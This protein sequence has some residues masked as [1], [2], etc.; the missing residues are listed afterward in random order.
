M[1]YLVK[2]KSKKEEYEQLIKEVF[3]HIQYA[4]FETFIRKNK[5][6]IIVFDQEEFL[7][8]IETIKKLSR[9]EEL[10]FVVV[11]ISKD[12]STYDLP[13]V[14]VVPDFNRDVMEKIKSRILKKMEKLTREKIKNIQR[15]ELKEYESVG[16]GILIIDDEE[17]IVYA[18]DLLLRFLK[19]KYPLEKILNLKVQVLMR[20]IA[21]EFDIEKL[22]NQTSNQRIKIRLPDGTVEER[23]ISVT[24]RL[25]AD[26]KIDGYILRIYE[27]LA[28]EGERLLKDIQSL[29]EELENI[30]QEVEYRF[31]SVVPG[32][33]KKFA[34]VLNLRGLIFI[35]FYVAKLWEF[36]E[37]TP[38]IL[39]YKNVNGEYISRFVYGFNMS[40]EDKE[41]CIGSFSFE[42]FMG[43]YRPF[44]DIMEVENT[45][46]LKE[47]IK[48]RGK[49]I[50][51]ILCLER[52]ELFDNRERHLVKLFVQSL[53]E[54]IDYSIYL[55][56]RHLVNL[57]E[58]LAQSHGNS[59]VVVV[60]KDG[61]VIYV[62]EKF[63][64]IFNLKISNIYDTSIE[65]IP[66]L[67][68]NIKVLNRVLHVIKNSIPMRIERWIKFPGGEEKYLIISGIPASEI[69]IPGYIWIFE[70]R[71]REKLRELREYYF[72]RILESNTNITKT[73]RL[74]WLDISKD[75]PSEFYESILKIFVHHLAEISDG[76][77]TTLIDPDSENV[78]CQVSKNLPPKLTG[79]ELCRFINSLDDLSSQFGELN[80]TIFNLNKI[81]HAGALLKAGFEWAIRI[82]ISSE[83]ENERQIGTIVMLS[84]A[85]G[86]FYRFIQAIYNPGIYTLNEND[87]NIFAQVAQTMSYHVGAFR[88][89]VLLAETKK[90]HE[91]FYK[92]S[93]DLFILADENRKITLAN[94]TA[95]YLLCRE[96]LEGKDLVNVLRDIVR[97][98]VEKLFDLQEE[99]EESMV[100]T[101]PR[102]DEEKWL[103]LIIKKIKVG[104]INEFIVIGHDVSE[105]YRRRLSRNRAIIGLIAMLLNILAEK[106]AI[107][108][109]HSIN[110]A[111]IVK[112]I[113]EV[114]TKENPFGGRF[115]NEA[116][117]FCL[118]TGALL[119]DI[120]KINM[121]SSY[122]IKPPEQLNENSLV[123][124]YYEEHPLFGAELLS[125]L[126]LPCDNKIPKWVMEHHECLDGSGFPKG[127]VGD[128]ISLGGRIIGVADRI[129]NEIIR[130]P[131][132]KGVEDLRILLR[133]MK[134]SGKYDMKVLNI[135]E[136]IYE[137]KGGRFLLSLNSTEKYEKREADMREAVDELL[138][139]LLG[140]E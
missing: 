48:G 86:E 28:F 61:S 39:V 41:K 104:D 2:T 89:N 94:D 105:F 53:R 59:G 60:E 71:T 134:D 128:K 138:G 121:A 91:E 8:K 108:A 136:K 97:E 24:P 50:Y 6:G 113:L 18:N 125:N 102:C 7:K 57:V 84:R 137:K 25:R 101:L 119:H 96:D 118:V 64:E 75:S 49:E 80:V 110:V 100:V 112:E 65:T 140:E 127:L 13:D 131:Q 73:L 12:L 42:K 87:Q 67:R 62:N 51:G 11:V 78:F 92:H 93:N 32:I 19:N 1:R 23:S 68:D 132:R 139:P 9:E 120:G 115:V 111:I 123:R 70:D 103:K 40:N 52:P 74:K 133:K 56:E 33:L 106:S 135:V 43:L 5:V 15:D 99:E 85:E 54:L 27:P 122:L 66:G 30:G 14:Y 76:L 17:K 77:I 88:R 82:P 38:F 35:P 69:N 107:I 3:P 37:G 36:D 114:I 26:N 126:G 21:P 29:I 109:R 81:P 58:K 16:V 44:D 47:F 130:K 45:V 31:F 129:E 79:S 98:D 46:S 116:D 95:R 72:R 63:G 124:R 4:D 20:E 117:K 83:V 55:P 10:N 34:R 22:F 90:L